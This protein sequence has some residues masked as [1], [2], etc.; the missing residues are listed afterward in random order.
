MLPSFTSHRIPSLVLLSLMVGAAS[1][2]QAAPIT[3]NVNL[4][5]GNGTVTGNIITDGRIGTLA[6]SNILGVVLRLNNGADPPYN[7]ILL[8]P[9]VPEVAVFGSDLSATPSQLLFNFSGADQGVF[10][11]LDVS[12]DFGVSFCAAG[13]GACFYPGAPSG[14]VEVFHFT[15]FPGFVPANQ[16]TSTSGTQIIGNAA[17]PASTTYTY[18]GNPYNVC[19]GTYC[20]GG[21]YALSLVFTT[22]LTGSALANLPFANITSAITSFKFTDESGFYLDNS[23]SSFEDFYLSTD[24]LGNIVTWLMDGCSISCYVKMQTSWDSPFDLTFKG[25]DLSHTSLFDVG[26][27]DNDPGTWTTPPSTMV[28]ILT[29]AVQNMQIPQQGTSLTD[30]LQHVETDIN[31]QNGQACQDLKAFANHVKAQTGKTI[32]TTQANQILTA[33]ANI[34]AA[35]KCGP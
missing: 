30:Q 3:Y 17:I 20:S 33:A 24:A 23:N 27:I 8:P 5:I 10:S 25:S 19:F 11:I 7:V 29:T 2:C 35:L 32:T 6:T 22:S 28:A 12:F 31:T 1:I 21:P 34:E 16:F 9:I 13:G 26:R 18:H 15:K 4:T 14:P